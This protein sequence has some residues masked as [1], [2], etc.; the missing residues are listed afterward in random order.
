[1]AERRKCKRSRAWRRAWWRAHVDAWR[2]SGLSG[3]EYCRRHGLKPH[4]F[5]WW[6]GVFACEDGTPS[7]WSGT[8]SPDSTQSSTAVGLPSPA[9]VFTEIPIACLPSASCGVEVV[10]RGERRVRVEPGFDGETLVR[11]VQVLEELA[12]EGPVRC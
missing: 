10:L 7:K 12:A 2:D 4:R 8:E 11:V 1:M 3:A 9:S 5:Y 6:R